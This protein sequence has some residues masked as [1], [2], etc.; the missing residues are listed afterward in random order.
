MREHCRSVH[1]STQPVFPFFWVAPLH[2][3]SFILSTLRGNHLII[4]FLLVP[5]LWRPPDPEGGLLLLQSSSILSM[6]RERESSITATNHP[7]FCD[8]IRPFLSV[9]FL[10]DMAVQNCIGDAFRGATWVALHNGGGTGWWVLDSFQGKPP[11]FS[12]SFVL[13]LQGRGHQRRLRPCPRRH[14]RGCSA[15]KGHAKLGRIKRSGQKVR[16]SIQSALSTVV[17]IDRSFYS[18]RYPDF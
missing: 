8:D 18:A 15:R 10:P 12:I 17:I 5:S 3:L 9:L 6:E 7:L 13:F 1:L 11:L 16:E 4:I 2:F 14:C